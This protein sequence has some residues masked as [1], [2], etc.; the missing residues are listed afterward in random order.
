MNRLPEAMDAYHHTADYY[1]EH[2]IAET[3]HDY[4]FEGIAWAEAHPRSPWISVK[5]RLPKSDIMCIVLWE[6]ELGVLRPKIDKYHLGWCFSSPL[7]Q[8]CIKYWM[9]LPELPKEGDK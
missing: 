5:K 6:D 2:K 9:P 1:H 8:P 4:F 7:S 3:F